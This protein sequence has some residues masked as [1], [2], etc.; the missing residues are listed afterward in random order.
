MEVLFNIGKGRD[1]RRTFIIVDSNSNVKVL[2]LLR[3]TIS[4]IGIVIHEV[5][6]FYS[7]IHTHTH[8]YN[9]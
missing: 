6:S 2:S 9:K 7:S 8:I 4:E 3:N 1:P 5:F